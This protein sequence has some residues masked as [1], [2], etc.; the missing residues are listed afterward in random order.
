MSSFRLAKRFQVTEHFHRILGSV[1]R[2]QGITKIPAPDFFLK[3]MLI[4]DADWKREST[5]PRSS[6]P[7]S[8]H[9]HRD[10]EKIVVHQLGKLRPYPKELTIPTMIFWKP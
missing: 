10:T 4:F 5:A 1:F 7:E 8:Q 3:S 6:K 2:G 9:G